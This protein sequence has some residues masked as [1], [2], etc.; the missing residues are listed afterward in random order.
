MELKAKKHAINAETILHVHVQADTLTRYA[1]LEDS[2]RSKN[3][4]LALKRLLDVAIALALIILFLPF[5]LLITLLIK[6]TSRGPVLYSSERVGFRGNHFYCYKFRSMVI[7]HSIKHHDHKQA[8]KGQEI[9]VL[10]KKKDDTRITHVG[11]I[12]RKTSMD[13]LPQ[14]FNVLTGDMSIIGPR[15]LV[16]FML[17]PYPEFRAV[18][19]LVRPGITGLWQVTARARSTSA[20]GAMTTS[21]FQSIVGP[22][23]HGYHTGRRRE[24][25]RP[26]RRA[27]MRS[28]GLPPRPRAGRQAHHVGAL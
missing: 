19:S 15:P 13:E 4:Q 16:P 10:H 28:D 18:R 14:L 20:T 9:G 25:S 3:A 17:A 26:R 27:T 24:R 23:L 12:I 22:P 5:L 7:D 8:V 1:T 11:R 6:L 2:L 21:S